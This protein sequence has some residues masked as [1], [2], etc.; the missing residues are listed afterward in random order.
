MIPSG[1]EESVERVWPGSAMSDIQSRYDIV[2]AGGGMAGA[3]FA[4]VAAR[5]GFDV[6][7]VEREDR[8]RDRVRGETMH[9]WGVHEAMLLGLGELLSHA[10]AVEIPGMR[11]HRS[12]GV[13]DSFLWTERS[14]GGRPMLGFSHPRLQETAW[15]W[16]AEQGATGI[17]PAKVIDVRPGSAPEAVVAAPGREVSVSAAL[18]VG[19]EGGGLSRRWIGGASLGDPEHHRVGGALFSGVDL[20]PGIFHEGG[21]PGFETYAFERGAGVHRVYI[22]GPW[23]TSRG[24]SI[25]RSAD[26]YRAFVAPIYPEGAF[27]RARHDG[28]I[29]FFPNA[30]TWAS[31]IAGDG[32]ALIGDAAGRSDPSRGHGTS[33]MMRDIRCLTDLVA[34]AGLTER[35]LAAYAA[36]REAYFAPVRALS[37]WESELTYATDPDAGRRRERYQRA[38]EQDPTLGGFRMLEAIGPDG[39]VPDEAA[40][41]HYFGEDLE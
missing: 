31:R 24:R 19:A 3:I 14:V 27:D 16:A 38:A 41:R 20:E 37:N 39:L 11:I 30:A 28:P 7:V 21:V 2:V 1:I 25:P 10:G 33:L 35:A 5:L 29:G 32:V 36:R 17:R 12:G 22:I 15:Q 4:G 9:P 34:D 8:F 6:L 26:A 13:V 23:E 40:R 18:V